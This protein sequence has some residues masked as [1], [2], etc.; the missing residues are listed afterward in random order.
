M[1]TDLARHIRD[2]PD[3]PKPGVVFKDITPLLADATAFRATV[4]QLVERYR[5]RADMVLGIESRGFI[6][7]A[8]VAYG[9]GTGLAVVRKPGKLPAR[10]YAARY[11]LEYGS[12]ALEIHHDAV[13][14]HHRVLI[15]DDLL[16]TGGTASAAVELV[17]RCG[18][19]VVACAFVIELAFLNGRQRL[20][21][22]DV[23]A[24][25]RYDRP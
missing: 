25:V 9:L 14:D 4:D 15:V 2:I 21:G 24:L 6:I 20:A 11:D 16:A 5:G 23:F 1:R 17:Q 13:G 18:G 22:Q 7:G 12:D 3:F 19:R 8:A 10:T